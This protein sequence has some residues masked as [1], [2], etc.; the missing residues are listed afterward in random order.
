MRSTLPNLVQPLAKSQPSKAQLFAEIKK[1][2]VTST[3]QLKTFREDWSSEQTQQVFARARD[4]ESKDGDLSA[5]F[6]VPEFGWSEAA[7]KS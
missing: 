6:G 5:R 2:A 4:S 3:G 1:A 7:E